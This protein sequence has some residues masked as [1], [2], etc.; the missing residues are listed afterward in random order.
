MLS[1]IFNIYSIIFL[2]LP[3]LLFVS[4]VPVLLSC[5]ITRPYKMV[6][7]TRLVMA[8]FSSSLWFV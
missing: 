2:F 7:D 1:N 6:L 3:S 8:P 5:I 4:L